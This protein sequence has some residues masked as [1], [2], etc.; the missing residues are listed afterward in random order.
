VTRLYE[1]RRDLPLFSKALLLH[2]MVVSKHDRKTAGAL[3]REI[4]GELILSANTAKARENVGD[5]YAMLMDSPVRSTAMVLRALL[6]HDASHP[7]APK[8]ARALLEARRGGTW[9]STQETAYSLLAL[10]E[11]RRAQEKQVPD[12]VATVWLGQS[13]VTR[14]RFSGRSALAEM[15][16]FPLAKLGAA[17]SLLTFRKEGN[18]ILFYEARLTYAK[19]V[20]PK[21]PLDRGFFVQKTLRPV[22]IEDLPKALETMASASARALPAGTLVLADVLVVTPSPRDYVVIDDP[23]PAGLEAIDARLA[24]TAR[25]LDPGNQAAP[26]E[27]CPG[28]TDTDDVARG[29]PFHEVWDRRELRDDR[30]LYFADHLPAGMYRYRYLARATTYGSFVVPPTKAEEMYSP[31]VFGRTGATALEVR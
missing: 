13:E 14:E 12:F 19:R 17:G 5:G 23:L 4:E 21:D 28:C 11:Y 8:L 25:W 24:T 22:S 29:E 3:S 1:A 7:L 26:Q 10:D 18:G 2:A 20:L 30:V 9:R 15:S 27:P 16:R 6:A 31:E